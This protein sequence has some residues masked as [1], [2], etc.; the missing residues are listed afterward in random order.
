MNLT[1]L[2]DLDDTLLDNSMEEFLPA[3][4]KAISAHL[5]SLVEPSKLVGA[6]LA[7]TKKM[8]ENRNPECTLKDVF[9]AYFY[10]AIGLERGII[11]QAIEQFYVDIFPA[12][13]G[14]TRP[15]PEAVQV[16]EEA[17]RRG[18]QVA[19]ATNPLFPLTAVLQRLSWAGFT[20]E[21]HPFAFIPSI[22]TV[23]F[24][25]PDPACLAEILAQTGWPD[26]P[27]VMIGD[28]LKADIH[29]AHDLG[30]PSY[31]LNR[32][33]SPLAENVGLFT[34]S[35]SLEGLFPWLDSL[36]P[37][38][39]QPDYASPTAIMAILRST[40]AAL[41]S[42]MHP[43]PVQSWS[44]RPQPGEWSLT[45]IICHLRDVDAEVNYQRLQQVLQQANPFLPG[46]DTDPWAEQRSYI[47]QDGPNALLHFNH[48]RRK[49]ISLLDKIAP[50][51]W[52]RSARHAIFG[53]TRLQELVSIIVAH[54]RLH[55]TQAYEALQPLLS[56]SH[57]YQ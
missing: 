23:H 57:N 31:W 40:P 19:I 33:S 9:Y 45:E 1:L 27:A 53:P 30:I 54:D 48:I 22:E 12:L 15:R 14:L 35:G 3:Y 52:Q 16:V 37:E 55:I 26:Q 36:P 34:A 2:F 5:A 29:A 10:P 20:P 25:K 18:Y 50:Q 51:D 24:A 49:I 46:Q 4:L 11:N 43:V 8:L 32:D 56:L 47:T 17:F 28:D 42:M 38:S 7:G 41:N 6:L 21:R 44:S 39:L 13:R